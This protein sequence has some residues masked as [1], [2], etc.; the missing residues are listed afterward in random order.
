M[1]TLLISQDL[2]MLVSAGYT[3]PADQA[4]YNAL[5]VD[6]KTE[7]KGIGKG[8]LKLFLFFKRESILQF[9]QRLQNVKSPIMLGIPWRRYT[10]A[11]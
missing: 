10:R 2:W 3:E 4:A 8:M 7:L 5:P 1:R 6:Q 11:L 9:F